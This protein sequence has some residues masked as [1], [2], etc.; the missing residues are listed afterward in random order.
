MATVNVYEQYF[1]ASCEYNGVPRKAALVMLTA[2]SC[3]GS[4][5]YSAGA[6]AAPANSTIYTR[7]FPSK[8]PASAAL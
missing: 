1:E 7:T 8:C 2:D 6:T 3:D 5:R 4:I